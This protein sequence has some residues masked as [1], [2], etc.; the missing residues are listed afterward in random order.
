MAHLCSLKA[1]L[2]QLKRQE[3]E[4][5]MKSGG[6]GGEGWDVK[7]TGDSRV[8]LIGFPSVGKST[9]L[10]K[11]TGTHS[12]AAAY[13]FTTLTCIPG[14]IRYKGAK[15]QLLDLPGIIEGT[16]PFIPSSS[17]SRLQI[18]YTNS[19]FCPCNRAK[20]PCGMLQTLH[21]E[22]VACCKPKP[23]TLK[24]SRTAWEL[25]TAKDGGFSKTNLAFQQVCGAAWMR[26][27]AKRHVML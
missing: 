13:E 11:L 6:G 26:E 20:A 25:G 17:L 27:T 1:Q 3:I 18:R 5:Q 4:S 7:S 8:G 2:A 12:E 21:F 16:S 15:I 10:T 24:F 19:V 23:C 9:L 14:I 22:V